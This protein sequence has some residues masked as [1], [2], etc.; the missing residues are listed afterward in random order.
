MT[1]Q[2]NSIVDNQKMYISKMSQSV[3]LSSKIGAS[4]EV[5]TQKQLESFHAVLADLASSKKKSENLLREELVR[6]R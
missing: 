5:L 6:E 1:E 3:S 4:N 2:I